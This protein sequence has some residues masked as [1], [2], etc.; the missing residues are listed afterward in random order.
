MEVSRFYQYPLMP[1]RVRLS[2]AEGRHFVSVLRGKTGQSI[3]LFDGQ[4]CLADG[5]ICQIK[6]ND[7]FV[8]VGKISTFPP[9]Q[10][11]RVILATA[12]AKGQRFDWMLS[13]CTELGADHIALVQYERSVRLGRESAAQRY[14]NL[15]VA[16][17][18]QCG[19]VFLPAITGPKKLNETLLELEHQYSQ[20]RIVIGS[21]E[22]SAK[23]ISQ[24]A[25]NSKDIVVFIGPEGG[26]TQAETQLLEHYGAVPVRIG[27]YI[28]RT[29]TAAVAFAAILES[30]RVNTL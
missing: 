1:G 26:L 27:N 14:Q 6:K 12:A 20:P 5:T 9:R 23:S 13:K 28:L 24:F 18:K 22:S 15:A 7:V 30:L 2:A 11:G 29:E 8:E 10:N 17:C 19:R 16:A 21:L 25:G 3:E 4:G